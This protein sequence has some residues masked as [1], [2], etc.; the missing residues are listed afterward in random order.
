MSVRDAQQ[1]LVDA[2]TGSDT[3]QAAAHR[4]HG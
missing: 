1:V 3:E 4:A 2:T